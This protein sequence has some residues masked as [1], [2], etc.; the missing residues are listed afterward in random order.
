MNI[1]VKIIP[2]AEQRYETPGDWIYNSDNDVLF[3][4]VSSLDNW[5]LESLIGVHEINEAILCIARGINEKDVTAF[6]MW[7]EAQRIA[8][9]PECQFEPGDH[10]KAP[11]RKEHFFATNVERQLAAELNVNWEDYDAAIE[12]L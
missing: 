7:Y 6:D 4:F 5:M 8:K 12:A 3:V 11:Y 10:K 2:H 9:N 1:Q